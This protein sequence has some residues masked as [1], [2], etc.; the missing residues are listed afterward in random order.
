MVSVNVELSE[1]LRNR[2]EE[3]ARSQGVSLEDFVRSCLSARLLEPSEWDS[4]QIET[5]RRGLE[6][7]RD[8]IAQGDVT[9]W[10]KEAFLAERH[11]ERRDP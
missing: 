6:E 3:A 1:E 5:V 2:A 10:D 4:E 8:A 9:P 11:R 7:A